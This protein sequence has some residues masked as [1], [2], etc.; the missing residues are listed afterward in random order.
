MANE[1]L[2]EE[3]IPAR[4]KSLRKL[5]EDKEYEIS[6][7]QRDYVWGKEHIEQLIE[8][9]INKFEEGH[10]KKYPL[11]EGV[12]NYDPY[13]MGPIIVCETHGD[14]PNFIIDGQQ[15]L[16]SLLL[17]LIFLY[18]KDKEKH[19]HLYSYI[20]KKN[21]RNK[22]VFKLNI[23]ERDKTMEA[24]WEKGKIYN[25]N[26]QNISLKNLQEGYQ[27]ITKSHRLE[28][29]SDGTLYF[30]NWLLHKV[31]MVEITIPPN[32]DAY[33]IFE[34][35]NDR[36][37]SLTPVEMLKGYL[38]D[39]IIKNSR[40]EA[41]KDWEK[42]T[43]ELQALGSKGQ[44]AECI[45]AWL[46]GQR[47]E[48]ERSEDFES[49]APQFHRW[50]RKKR[51]H[52]NLKDSKDFKEFIT[53]DFAFYSKWY[54]EIY[55]WAHTDY[56]KNFITLYSNAY[57][58]CTL[59]FPALLAAIPLGN[60]DEDKIHIRIKL[61]S[62]YIDILLIRRIWNRKRFG[63]SSLKT[64]IFSSV[65]P[66]IKGKSIK[67]IANN[68]KEN[69]D[70]DSEQIP[71]FDR[72]GSQLQSNDL[73]TKHTRLILARITNYIE[74]K[75]GAPNPDRF[76]EYINK[77]SDKKKFFH[78][79]HIL[80]EKPKKSKKSNNYDEYQYS[81]DRSLIGALLLLPGPAN[82]S[83][84]NQSYEE[85]IEHYYGQNLLAKSLYKTTY[86]AGGG[87]SGFNK[88]REEFKKSTGVKFNSYKDFT[89][90]AIKERCDLYFAIAK[91][92]WD[93]E[94]LTRIAEGKEEE[95]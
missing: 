65:I 42:N 62:T 93:P 80:P 24:L 51:D 17:L 29:L 40:E 15:R 36:G 58:N 41:K 43:Q 21:V 50:V 61:V 66:T 55:K 71:S 79:E 2:E 12:E 88:F 10:E 75:C 56:Q 46:R 83:F 32:H 38:L 82:E 1:I 19:A 27:C 77:V 63:Q 31:K 86:R 8:D 76:L 67:K 6:Y 45:I 53:K 25:P 48:S 37:V 49:I 73:N 78:I 47:A 81:R 74:D 7:Y 39:N 57:L 35:M 11:E 69:L 22:F 16:T 70:K 90:D 44:D 60:E 95:E 14:N 26:E 23:S 92:I 18:R 4:T 28:N 9:L 89:V 30:T 5:L 87:N 59:Q 64:H 91:R 72:T 52:L 85:K 33:T 3:E 68:L 54:R 13:F 34:T 84:S 20:G 94:K